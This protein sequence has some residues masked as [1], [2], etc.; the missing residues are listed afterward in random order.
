MDP[1]PN[2]CLKFEEP[3]LGTSMQ[4]TVGTIGLDQSL[5]A[6]YYTETSL[7]NYVPFGIV[8]L[9]VVVK[10]Y[11]SEGHTTFIFMV[12]IFLQVDTE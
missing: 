5:T 4:P 6:Y 7:N 9:C 11:I 8:G 2:G 10:Y 3:A 1:L 12:T